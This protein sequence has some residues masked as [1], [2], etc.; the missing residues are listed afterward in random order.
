MS[1]AVTR[2][3]SGE[4]SD[5]EE[6][7][8]VI[9]LV[10]EVHPARAFKAACDEI[11]VAGAHSVA[12]VVNTDLLQMY[13]KVNRSYPANMLLK[14]RS[15]AAELPAERWALSFCTQRRLFLL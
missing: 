4:K 15:R 2:E 11:V 7:D 5:S 6:Q 1:R 9:E 3:E 12:T 13:R 8:S 10:N 14:S